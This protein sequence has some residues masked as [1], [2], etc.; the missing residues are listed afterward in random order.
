M[1]PTFHE[2]LRNGVELFNRQEFYEAHEA[3]EAGWIDELGD[4][5]LLLQGL[6]QVAAG[7]YK[8]Q[9]GAPIGTVK[10]LDQGLKKLRTFINNPLGLD[11]GELIPATEEWFETA[12]ELVRTG[13]TDYDPSKLPTIKVTSAHNPPSK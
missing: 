8:L 5:R 10:L 11:L 7:F 6:I 12:Q 3:W 4:E 2:S 1:G 13:R 9:T